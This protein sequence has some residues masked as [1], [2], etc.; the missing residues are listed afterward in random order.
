MKWFCLLLLPLSLMA[1]TPVTMPNGSTLP[2]KM[3]DGV[4]EFHL[5]AEPIKQEFSP[6]MV[7]NCWGYNGQS[8]G[9]VIEAVEGDR[10]RILVTNKL[11]EPTTV[12]WHGIIL[13][14]GMDGV[15]ALTQPE[16]PPGETFVYEFTLKQN[17]TYMYHPHYDDITQI[18]MGMMGFFIIHPKE[19]EEEPV[20]RDFVI[21]LMAWSIPAGAATPNVMTMDLNYFTFNSCFFPK[22]EPLVIRQ[23]QKVRIRYGNLSLIPHPIHLHGY[24]FM[25]TRMGAARL[26]E[27]AQW[28]T[29]TINVPVGTTRDIEF[30]ADNPGDWA[31]HCH[32]T[33]HAA[34]N[35]MGLGTNMLGADQGEVAKRIAALIPGYMPMGQK[36]FGNM[37][38]EKHRQIP[39]PSNFVPWGVPGQFG[40]IE[41]SGMFTV[42]KVREGITSYE[43]PGWY[44]HPPGT[45]AHLLE[46]SDSSEE[47]SDEIGCFDK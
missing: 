46:E 7:V 35:G 13:P 20:D 5:I 37:F 43:D 38:T 17:G 28:S 3:V 36:G 30:T 4:K 22:T 39:R 6:G 29:V 12:H 31:M 25:V 40:N 33:H 47:T 11:P 19:P 16:I 2:Y 21:M 10:V 8:P 23:G 44:R 14:N 26:P 24:E 18:G 1:Y 42:V 32:I 45:T 27:S 41:L 34:M 15:M 9:P